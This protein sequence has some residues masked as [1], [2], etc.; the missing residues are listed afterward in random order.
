[1]ALTMSCGNE[2]HR[3]IMLCVEKYFLLSLLNLFQVNFFG[4]FLDLVFWGEG[5]EHKN[6][7][8]QFCQ[9]MMILYI[10][11]TVSLRILLMNK[12]SQTFEPFLLRGE[13]MS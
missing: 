12:E 10:L 1:M 8:T 13:F 9:A 5:E 3:L 7:P 11:I 4:R 6:L 2:L